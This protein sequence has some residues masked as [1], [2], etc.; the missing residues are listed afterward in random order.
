[1]VE[2][3]DTVETVET[4]K[5][6]K[7][8]NT[9]DGADVDVDVDV[10]APATLV[11]KARSFVEA[12]PMAG[13]P[14]LGIAGFMGV[15]FVI[16]VVKTFAKSNF[17]SDGKRRK[18]INANKLVIDELQKYLPENRSALKGSAIAGIRLRTGFRYVVVRVL[19]GMDFFV[20]APPPA[21]N[22]SLAAA[23]APAQSD[24]DFPQVP[25][26]RAERTQ[27]RP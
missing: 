19:S 12:N 16:A 20:R 1:M 18:K 4:V 21:A 22:N 25:V 3:V 7:T 14:L 8:V 11:G 23:P 24:G 2:P 13:Y 6:V 17:T 27:V 9:V 15:T 5:T 26:V 10:E